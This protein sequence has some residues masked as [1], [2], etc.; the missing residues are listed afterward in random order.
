MKPELNEFGLIKDSMQNASRL[1]FFRDFAKAFQECIYSE[2]ISQALASVTGYQEHVSWQN[3]FFDRSTG[4]LEHQ[5]SWYL[6]TEPAG[7]LVGVWY[8][9][10]DIRDASGPFFIAPGSHKIGLLDRAQIPAHEDFVKAVRSVAT[11]KNLEMSKMLLDKG[12]II[13]WHPFTIHGAYQNSDPQLSRKSFTCHFYPKGLKA[14]D[15]EQGKLV[16]IYDH[17]KPKETSNPN[18]YSAYRYD[19]RVYNVLVYAKYLWSQL[20]RNKQYF[21]MRR[22]SNPSGK[23]ADGKGL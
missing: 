18:I 6:D 22:D 3:M 2:N 5:D 12:D 8:A 19:D 21:V 23:G 14:K 7:H 11:E 15:I 4:T 17:D 9:L 13:L 20:K 16:S 10:E 1:A